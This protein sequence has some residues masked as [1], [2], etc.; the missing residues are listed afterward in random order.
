MAAEAL[1]AFQFQ[2]REDGQPSDRARLGAYFLA[3]Q[4]VIHRMFMQSFSKGG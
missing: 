2:E 3:E 1:L 4:Y